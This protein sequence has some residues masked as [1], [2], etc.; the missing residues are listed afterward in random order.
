MR[1][2]DVVSDGFYSVGILLREIMQKKWHS[3]IIIMQGVYNYVPEAVFLSYIVFQLFC[4]LSLWCM[5]CYSPVFV[6]LSIPCIF[7]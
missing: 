6:K 3:N 7:M 5:K 2:G 1:V 4:S